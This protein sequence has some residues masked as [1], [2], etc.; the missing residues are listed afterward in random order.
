MHKD[1]CALAT[2]RKPNCTKFRANL[3]PLGKVPAS[4]TLP[5]LDHITRNESKQPGDEQSDEKSDHAD[6]TRGRVPAV[7][8][9]ARDTRKLP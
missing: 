2:R 7:K 1:L 5:D 9:L 8:F 4:A 6:E 3:V